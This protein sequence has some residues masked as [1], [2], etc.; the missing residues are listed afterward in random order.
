VESD[1]WSISKAGRRLGIK[2]STA[3]V[4]YRRYRETGKF[5]MK[6]KEKGGVE[7]GCKNDGCEEVTGN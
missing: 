2:C 7:E 3:K 5:F 1:G 6:K 4:I